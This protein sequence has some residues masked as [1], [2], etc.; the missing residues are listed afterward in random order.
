MK[1]KLDFLV[2]QRNNRPTLVLDLLIT[3]QGPPAE[4]CTE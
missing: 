1:G 2:N 3:Q 4:V